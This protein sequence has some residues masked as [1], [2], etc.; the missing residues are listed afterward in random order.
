MAE[1]T[2]NKQ[3]RRRTVIGT[4]ISS[5]MDKTIV[6]QA[7]RLTRHPMYGKFY[8]KYK[9]FKAHDE[10][11]ECEVG[12]KVSIIESRPLSKHKRFRLSNIIEKVKKAV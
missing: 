3:I 7:N 11:N 2:T 4:V 6:V 1:T 5:K 8:T 10:K 12:D 9:K